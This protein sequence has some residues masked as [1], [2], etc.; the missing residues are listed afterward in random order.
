MLLHFNQLKFFQNQISKFKKIFLQK[1][2]KKI[3]KIFQHLR[4]GAPAEYKKT[5]F[6]LFL[7]F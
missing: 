7:F 4:G 1:K 3:L 6:T 5:R 2:I